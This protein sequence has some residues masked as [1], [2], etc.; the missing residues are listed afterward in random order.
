MATHA[1][2]ADESKEAEA[3][4]EMEPQVI[5]MKRTKS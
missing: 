3:E 4:P 5:I 2:G 1:E